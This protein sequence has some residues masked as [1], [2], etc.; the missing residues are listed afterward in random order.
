[1]RG[2]KRLFSSVVVLK[3]GLAGIT[4]IAAASSASVRGKFD[5]LKEPAGVKGEE[6]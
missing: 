6:G 5:G 2:S 4:G 3:I 1:M